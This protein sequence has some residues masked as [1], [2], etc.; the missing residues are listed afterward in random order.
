MTREAQQR[1]GVRSTDR[2]TDPDTDLSAPV[3]T[4]INPIQATVSRESPDI[5]N[6]LRPQT[7]SACVP[8]CSL[9]EPDL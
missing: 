7:L 6:L 3:K 1:D 8:G 4:D 5:A 2:T 9:V